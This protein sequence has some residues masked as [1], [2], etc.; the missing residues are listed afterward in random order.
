MQATLQNP[1]SHATAADIQRDL[2]KLANDLPNAFADMGSSQAKALTTL[3]ASIEQQYAARHGNALSI[4]SLVTE[5]QTGFQIIQLKNEIAEARIDPNGRAREEAAAKLLTDV[6]KKLD[7]QTAQAFAAEAKQMADTLRAN[8]VDGSRPA[9]PTPRVAP[10]VTPPT[11]SAT[12]QTENARQETQST[13][14]EHGRDATAAPKQSEPVSSPDRSGGPSRQSE[15]TTQSEKTKETPAPEKGTD[16][17]EASK[18]AA[19][20]VEQSS[21]NREKI[22]P[23]EPV[24]ACSEASAKVAS[25]SLNVKVDHSS[26]ISQPT[27][28]K[29]DVKETTLERPPQVN[30]KGSSPTPEATLRLD[31]NAIA[32]QNRPLPKS[33]ERGSHVTRQGEKAQ[34][35]PVSETVRQDVSRRATSNSA[36]SQKESGLTQGN[37]S[38][39]HN[40][41]SNEIVPVSARRLG[42]SSTSTLTGERVSHRNESPSRRESAI[43]SRKNGTSRGNLAHS[44]RTRPKE[45]STRS[46]RQLRAE[47]RTRESQLTARE[48]R[49]GSKN[50]LETAMRLRSRSNATQEK[51]SQKQTTQNRL[52]RE[53][54]VREMRKERPQREGSR[55]N[56]RGN[57]LERG[58]RVALKGFRDTQAGRERSRSS[59]GKGQGSDRQ[60]RNTKRIS[61]S[62]LSSAEQLKAARN[63]LQRINSRARSVDLKQRIRNKET[64]PR[65]KGKDLQRLPKRQGDRAKSGESL[66]AGENGRPRNQKRSPNQFPERS[67]DIR[68][69]LRNITLKD[70]PSEAALRALPPKVRIEVFRVK[71]KI[72]QMAVRLNH[73]NLPPALQKRILAELSLADVERLVAMTSGSKTSKARRKKKVLE[74]MGQTTDQDALFTL[75]D[76]VESSIDGGAATSIEQSA[77][78]ESTEGE[79]S[80]DTGTEETTDVEA[81]N[82][83]PTKT[84]DTVIVKESDSASL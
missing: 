45:G 59:Q 9:Y 77:P 81:D 14:A 58:R 3:L 2:T 65:L 25:S 20:R 28:Q 76:L 40:G 57:N 34:G 83:L 70:L 33:D 10:E 48:L 42:A 75:E 52:R 61:I 66:R 50:K 54:S 15:A 35:S 74:Q 36:S 41:V 60:L 69:A 12:R 24:T 13:R 43:A 8:G 63:L 37:K 11:P 22:V 39:P 72:Q 62:T 31:K 19:D 80:S 49:Q 53:N 26:A 29:S 18:K 55:N 56:Q 4:S 51:K 47:V 32:P 46:A 67:K 27:L 38:S 64:N 71:G 1:S 30:T 21:Q 82:N 73:L 16:Q 79:V 6:V 5:L 23:N 17:K 7:P 68:Q 78:S 84:L 44:N